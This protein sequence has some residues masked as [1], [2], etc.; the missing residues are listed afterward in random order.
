MS[1]AKKVEA[2]ECGRCGRTSKQEDLAADCCTCRECKGPTEYPGTGRLCG[3]CGLKD[4][5]KSNE[6][7]LAS[8]LGT[9]EE[10]REDLRRR[11]EH[12]A[13]CLAKKKKAR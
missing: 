10:Q 1:H 5:I 13:K 9:L 12:V 2:W 7:H 8:L 3:H 11:D 6:K 4:T